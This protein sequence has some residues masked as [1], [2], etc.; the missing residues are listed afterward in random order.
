MKRAAVVAHGGKRVL[1]LEWYDPKNPG[2]VMAIKESLKW[3]HVAEVRVWPRV[4]VDN[5]HNAKIDYPALL[6]MLEKAH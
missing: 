4:P 6:V 2:D 5:R 3:A 1:V